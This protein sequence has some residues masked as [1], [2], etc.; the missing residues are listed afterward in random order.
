[1]QVCP[2]CG[3]DDYVETSKKPDGQTLFMCAR[4]GKHDDQPYLWTVDEK[5]KDRQYPNEGLA[6]ELDLFADLRACFETEDGWLEYGV[7]EERFRN[8]FPDHFQDLRA[9][10]GSVLLD[11]P[12]R[13]SVASYISRH[14]LSKLVEWGEL[15]WFE[16]EATGV[17]AY[18][19]II[20]YWAVVP[21]PPREQR[22]SY[23]EFVR[24]SGPR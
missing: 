23:E 18:N 21:S 8:R 1:M 20:S 9:I 6:A 2:L 13:Y 16:G 15:D 4:E 10:Y 3:M 19:G 11:G 7:L 24:S 12:R 5:G 22:L 14:V 17:W